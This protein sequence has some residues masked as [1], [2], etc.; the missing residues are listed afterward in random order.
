MKNQKLFP[1]HYGV[2]FMNDVKVFFLTSHY[3]KSYIKFLNVTSGALLFHSLE[4]RNLLIDVL[5]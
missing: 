3:E 5:G 4:Y 2:F 1:V